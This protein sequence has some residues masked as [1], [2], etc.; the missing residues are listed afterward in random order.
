MRDPDWEERLDWEADPPLDTSDDFRCLG[1]ETPLVTFRR[2]FCAACRREHG[3][4]R[5]DD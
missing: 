3:W 4:D 1:C 2:R 5:D